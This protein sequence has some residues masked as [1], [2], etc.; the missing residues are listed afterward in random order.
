MNRTLLYSFLLFCSVSIFIQPACNNDDLGVDPD[1]K[2]TFSLDTLTFDTVFTDVGSTTRFFK[3]YN[4]NEFK[5]AVALDL[6]IF[7]NT[8]MNCNCLPEDRYF[9]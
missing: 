5:N 8:V 4:P 1:F 3:V 7:N 9:R 6:V 2:L